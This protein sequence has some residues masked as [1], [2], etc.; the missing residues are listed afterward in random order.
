M[1]V[2]L[3]DPVVIAGYPRGLPWKYADNAK[4]FQLEAWRG[5]NNGYFLISAD[6]YKG[7]SGSPVVN[8]NSEKLIGVLSYGSPWNFT[9]DS[10][11]NC[12]QSWRCDESVDGGCNGFRVGVSRSQPFIE[13]DQHLVRELCDSDAF[14]ITVISAT[15]RRPVGSIPDAARVGVRPIPPVL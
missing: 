1:D 3:N 11:R 6:G 9:L 7:N 12:L 15:A 14:A 4:V 8:A 2:A 10:Q 13:G 5:G